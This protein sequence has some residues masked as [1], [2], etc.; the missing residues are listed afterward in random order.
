[1]EN[2]FTIEQVREFWDKVAPIYEPANK[3]VGYV[4]YQRFER[5]LKHAQVQPGHKVLN[6]WSRM[7]GLIPYIRQIANLTLYNREASPQFIASAENKFPEEKFALTDLENLSEFSDNY[8]DRIISLET[9]E[10]APKPLKFLQELERVLKPGG[11]LVLSLPPQGFE[12]PTRIWD[13]F[14]GNHGEGPHKFLWPKEVKQLL[15]RT[16]LKLLEHDP[17]MILPLKNDRLERISEKILTGLFKKTP[18]IN[19]GVRHFYVC[20]K[21]HK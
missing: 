14:F 16:N 3:K 20:E 21:N 10:H 8:F 17:T 4:H 13:K 12:I 5:G 1:M 2:N 11:R 9:L 15:G 19:F 6:I 7:G 18:I